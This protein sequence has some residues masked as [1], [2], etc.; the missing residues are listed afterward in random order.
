[1]KTLK[2][3]WIYASAILF[4]LGCCLV[5]EPLL[6]LACVLNLGLCGFINYDYITTDFIR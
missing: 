3:I 2:D 4:V 1:M 6:T 5:G